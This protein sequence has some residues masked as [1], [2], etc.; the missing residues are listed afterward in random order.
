MTQGGPFLVAAPWSHRAG[1]RQSAIDPVTS[2]TSQSLMDSPPT[3]SAPYQWIETSLCKLVISVILAAQLSRPSP[4]S[5]GHAAARS[6]TRA[7]TRRSRPRGGSYEEHGGRASNGFSRLP[8]RPLTD[9]SRTGGTTP[10]SANRTGHRADPTCVYGPR[11][12]DRTPRTDLR[13]KCSAIRAGPTVALQHS[14]HHG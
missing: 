10:D 2:G 11:R 3:R 6:L 8:P 7:W 4:P 14:G 5:P 13:I 1:K 12:T 9:L